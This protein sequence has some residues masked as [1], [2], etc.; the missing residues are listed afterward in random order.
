M[1]FLSGIPGQWK[2]AGLAGTTKQTNFKR[3]EIISAYQESFHQIVGFPAHIGYFICP[4]NLPL[5]G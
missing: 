1:E 3:Y 2:S 5:F 4:A